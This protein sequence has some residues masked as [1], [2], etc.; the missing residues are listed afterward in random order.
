MDWAEW[1]YPALILDNAPRWECQHCRQSQRDGFESI[2]CQGISTV[3]DCPIGKVPKLAERNEAFMFYFNRM[4]PGLLQ[5]DGGYDFSAE[6]FVFDLYDIPA[7]IQKIYHDRV[8]ILVS[9][10]SKLRERKY[11][12]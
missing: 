11:K 2:E 9:V 8:L 12:K 5:G 3:D 4:Q 7:G 10:I 1:F 6:K